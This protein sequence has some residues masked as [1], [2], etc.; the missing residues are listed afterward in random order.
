MVGVLP[1][2]LL[3]VA[4]DG[5]HFHGWQRQVGVRGG[6]QDGGADP[7][8]GVADNHIEVH[9]HALY[10]IESQAGLLRLRQRG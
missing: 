5:T 6:Q 9:G 1:T 4:Y 2:Y 3:T 7:G 8:A 10:D